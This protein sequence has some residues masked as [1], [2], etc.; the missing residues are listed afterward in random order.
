MTLNVS[1]NKRPVSMDEVSRSKIK[2]PASGPPPDA[3]IGLAI[4]TRSRVQS[5]YPAWKDAAKTKA[6]REELEREPATANAEENYFG[7][8]SDPV[9]VAKALKAV[10][11]AENPRLRPRHDSGGTPHGKSEMIQGLRHSENEEE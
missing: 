3:I 9:A 10:F 8:R 11:A 7:G 4:H 6:W 1:E 2:L 5:A